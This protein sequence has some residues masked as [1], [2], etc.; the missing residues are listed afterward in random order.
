VVNNSVEHLIVSQVHMPIIW[1]RNDNFYRSHVAERTGRSAE[2]WPK[3][4]RQ[5]Y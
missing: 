2:V 5:R 3:D 1:P 4:F